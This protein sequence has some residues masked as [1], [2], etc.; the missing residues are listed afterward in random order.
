LNA[1]GPTIKVLTGTHATSTITVTFS[2]VE[3][4]D[5]VLELLTILKAHAGK[6]KDMTIGGVTVSAG[7]RMDRLDRLIQQYRGAEPVG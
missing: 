3:F 7:D 6:Q 2:P 1:V 4:N 5:V